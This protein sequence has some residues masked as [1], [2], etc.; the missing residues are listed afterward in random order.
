MALNILITGVG[1]FLGSHILKELINFPQFHLFGFSRGYPDWD[2]SSL[3]KMYSLVDLQQGGICQGID[4]VVHCGFAR[5][6]S[7]VAL[8][9]SLDILSDLLLESEKFRVKGFINISSQSVYGEVVG[10]HSETSSVSPGYLYA[11]AKYA[12]EKMVNLFADSFKVTN[13]RLAGLAGGSPPRLAGVLAKFVQDVVEGKELIITNANSSLS[14]IDVRDASKG[15][16][17]L[18]EFSE[19][20]W[21]P[22][23]NLGNE[24]QIRVVDLAEAVREIG[25]KYV[26]QVPVQVVRDY[27]QS[28]N[29]RLNSQLLSTTTGWQPEYSLENM[30]ETVFNHYVPKT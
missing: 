18:I 22:V 12:S 2:S 19:V 9:Q 13:V 21:S 5:E 8:A 11:M 15:I 7:G 14:F 30:I 27:D 20:H 28:V 6:S 10:D 16:R 3:K 1:G 26:S 23:Y 17:S 24:W 4:L 29:A 25:K